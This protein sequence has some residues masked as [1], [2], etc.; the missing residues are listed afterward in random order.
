[1]NLPPMYNQPAHTGKEKKK[2][3]KTNIL[4]NIVISKG[5]KKKGHSFPFPTGS[6][7][8]PPP[9]PVLLHSARAVCG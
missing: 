1:M 7:K 5:N 3:V 8:S 9:L 2:K 6:I 4:L